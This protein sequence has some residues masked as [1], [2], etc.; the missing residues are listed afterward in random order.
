MTIDEVIALL[1]EQHGA[2]KRLPRRDPLSELI[3]ALL[4]Q[5]TSDVNSSRAFENLVATFD[6]WDIVAK[7]DVEMISRAISGGGLNRV[8]APR[9]K[10]ILERIKSEKGSLDLAFLKDMPL[11]EARAWLESLPG[12]GPK[13]AAC[14]LL[15]SLGRAALPVD[16]HV[17]RVSQRLGLIDSKVSPEDAHRILGKKVPPDSIYEF[18]LNMV[19]HGRR[20]CRSQSPL[21][22][23]CLLNKGC[24][25]GKRTLRRAG[26]AGR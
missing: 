1:R 15:F 9:I 7:A 21:C 14:V 12:V 16:T 11:P 13:T 4:S 20:V 24:A 23:G 8:K 17:Y 26:S 3:A 5:N 25:Y 18:H 19:R 6:T 22:G 10:A 2:P